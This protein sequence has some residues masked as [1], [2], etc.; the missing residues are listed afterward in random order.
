[1]RNICAIPFR[2]IMRRWRVRFFKLVEKLCTRCER[3]SASLRVF[4]H[5]SLA[6]YVP[7]RDNPALSTSDVQLACSLGRSLNGQQGHG[8]AFQRGLNPAVYKDADGLAF[9]SFFTS[10]EIA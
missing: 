5:F 6:C 9:H 2:I 1:M 3:I 7:I 8:G 4:A 10:V